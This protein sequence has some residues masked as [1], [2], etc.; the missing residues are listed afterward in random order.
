MHGVVRVWKSVTTEQTD[1]DD[2]TTCHPSR[3]RADTSTDEVTMASAQTT[4]QSRL[5]LVAE[6]E[7]LIVISLSRSRGRAGECARGYGGARGDGD[8]DR[9]GR[10]S[11]RERSVGHADDLS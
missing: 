11:G 6:G 1:V 10:R 3:R 5:E 7:V 2:T 4:T 8:R 9:T